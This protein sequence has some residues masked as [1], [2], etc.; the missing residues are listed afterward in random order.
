M[1]KGVFDLKAVFIFIFLEH[2]NNITEKQASK[3]E[4]PKMF[5]EQNT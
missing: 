1:L 4:V 2:E 5:E 3:T